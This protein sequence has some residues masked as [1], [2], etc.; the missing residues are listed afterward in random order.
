[1]KFQKIDTLS[2]LLDE[3]NTKTKSS[4]DFKGI[5]FRVNYVEDFSPYCF[6]DENGILMGIIPDVIREVASM[7]NVTLIFQEPNEM[8]KNIWLKRYVS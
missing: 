5:P 7:V 1:M 2:S 4:V 6:L 3:F 8:N